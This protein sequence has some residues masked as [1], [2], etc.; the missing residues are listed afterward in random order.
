MYTNIFKKHIQKSWLQNWVGHFRKL[1][2]ISR[3]SW[4]RDRSREYKKKIKTYNF[5]SILFFLQ[6]VLVHYNFKLK[7]ILK[8][9]AL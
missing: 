4:E 2:G 5:K 6:M 8:F 7:Y 3:G 1:T 9:Q